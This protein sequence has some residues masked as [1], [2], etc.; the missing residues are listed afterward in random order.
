LG[1]DVPIASSSGGEALI[2]V[3]NGKL[4]TLRI[5]Y[6]LGFFTKNVD[7][8]IDD[9]NGGWKGRAVWTTSGREIT[10]IVVTAVKNCHQKFLKFKFA[11]IL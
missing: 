10:S 3:V 7:G 11:Q 2:A 1:K 4:V 8:R 9:V 6:P 5:P